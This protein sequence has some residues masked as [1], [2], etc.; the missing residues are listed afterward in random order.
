MAGDKTIRISGL[1]TQSVVWSSSSFIT[2]S[3]KSET[4]GRVIIKEHQVEFMFKYNMHCTSVSSAPS[5]TSE[6]SKQKQLNSVVFLPIGLIKTPHA[7]IATQNWY[8][9]LTLI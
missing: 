8:H 2:D 5:Q 7:A 1:L 9:T 4:A 3:L 6:L